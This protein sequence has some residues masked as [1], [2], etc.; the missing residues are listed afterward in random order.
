MSL[1]SET[2]VSVR[3]WADSA[4]SV[5][6]RVSSLIAAMTLREKVAQL[7]GMWVGAS[8]DGEGV[9]PHQNDLG[10]DLDLDELLTHGLGQLTRAFGTT[11][12]EPAEGAASLAKVQRHIAAAGRFGI[13]ALVHE[14]CLAGF[15][16]WKAT[17]YPVPLAW[18]ATFDPA[19][20][21]EMAE[22]IG[23]SM[24]SVGV[25]QGLAPVLDVTRDPRWGRTEETIGEDP[26][27][28]GT[29][30]TA[31][32]R[33]LE[34]TGIVSTLKHFA[35]YS[36]SRG[37]RN[38]APV[39]MGPRELGD[40]ILPPFEMAVREGGVR[41]VMHSYS[42]IDGVPAAA[43]ERLLT[44]LLRDQWGF[45]GTVVAD[46]F[47]ISFLKLLHGVAGTW[48]EAA[49]LALTAGVD[50]ELPGMKTYA[51]PLIGEIESGALAESFVDRA[52]ERVL[53]Q[54][55][56]LGLLDADWSPLPEGWTE[57]DL[58]SPADRTGRVVFDGAED[59]ALARRIAER[60]VVLL[61][62]DGILPLPTTGSIAVVG[63]TAADAMTMLGCYSFPSHVGVHHPELPVGISISTV[64]EGIT[65]AFPGRAV[66]YEQGCSIDGPDRDGIAAAVEAA[67]AA[68]VVVVSLGDRA[69][70]FGRGTSGEGCDAD[71]LDLPGLQ[72][73][74]LEAVL[75]TGTPVVVVLVSGRPY[76]LGT[77]PERAAA[78]VQTFFP[79]EEGGTA[80]AS[81]LSGAVNPSGRLPVGVPS[82]TGGQP[83]TYL[84]PKLAKR[85]EV[86]NIDTTP[87]YPFG[88]GLGY[89]SFE[90]SALDVAA[91]A[92]VA[93]DGTARIGVTVR[94]T[95][96]RD[97][98]EIVQL[99]LHDPV[100]QVTRPVRRLI[101]YARV[102][103][104]AGRSVEVRFDVPADT[105]SFIGRDLVRV[106]E[107]GEIELQLGASSEDIRH[108]AVTELTG[109]L[110]HVD[111]TREL[112]CEVSVTTV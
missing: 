85:S 15:T 36:A 95:G 53:R 94:N 11:P 93:T 19:I 96:D 66:S 44:E 71:T 14:E 80:I 42:E 47:G 5:D 6:E 34:K 21:E 74:L 91:P 46:Y 81:V 27:L 108:T 68:D 112:H 82:R 64:L 51:D 38:L 39:P 31:Y 33:G 78:I 86:S 73:E 97:G 29:V 61:R 45:D 59:R 22:R 92:R 103:V 4:R 50:V 100:A 65:E 54:K 84:L 30:A 69:G 10:E 25:H 52:L 89:S 98:A 83:S 87:A 106:V 9:A 24:R 35:G 60:S 41:S 105:T 76:V 62:N 40:V 99:Y 109:P 67:R 79:G 7:Y 107:P 101:A 17:A 72:G 12:L 63:P 48:G 3:P 102:E 55:A 18:G 16:T 49:A 56:E 90:W 75:D 104:P 23:T 1:D 32:V 88:F 77:A 57:D 2:E 43:D 111:H 37:G 70:L 58:A 28:V 110:R 13:P 20:V 26:Y 8:T